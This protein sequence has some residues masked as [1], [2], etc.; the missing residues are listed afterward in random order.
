MTTKKKDITPGMIWFAEMVLAQA[1][2]G[3]SEGTILIR[4]T[5]EELNGQNK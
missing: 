3:D 5:I 1:G 4:E 2:I